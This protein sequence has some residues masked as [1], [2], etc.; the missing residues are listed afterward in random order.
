[1]ST[2]LLWTHENLASR[3][4]RVHPDFVAPSFRPSFNQVIAAIRAAGGP[5][6]RFDHESHV[7]T[8]ILAPFIAI[9][10]IA[11]TAGI[12]NKSGDYPVDRVRNPQKMAHILVVGGRQFKEA[13][14]FE[15][16]PTA[17]RSC[18]GDSEESRWGVCARRR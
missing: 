16:A 14:G 1:M 5:W 2:G 3:K 17:R 7:I 15:D 18:R 9:V 4:L 13:R 11:V 12:Q 6:I 8:R 10:V